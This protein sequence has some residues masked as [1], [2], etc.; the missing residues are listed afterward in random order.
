MIISVIFVYEYDIFT[1]PSGLDIAHKYLHICI[2]ENSTHPLP[3]SGTVGIGR[4]RQ[5]G[6]FPI[7]MRPTPMKRKKHNSV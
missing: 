5:S 4:S 7:L 3:R 6:R 2:Y 1:R